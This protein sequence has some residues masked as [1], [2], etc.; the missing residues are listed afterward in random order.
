MLNALYAYLKTL[1]FM[2]MDLDIPKN[3]YLHK[4]STFTVL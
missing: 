1:N 4:I 2:N 3:S